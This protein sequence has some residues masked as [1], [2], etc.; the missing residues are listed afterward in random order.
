MDGIKK[1]GH[2]EFIVL[3]R[4]SSYHKGIEDGGKIMKE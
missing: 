1:E 3:Q 4:A 2:R